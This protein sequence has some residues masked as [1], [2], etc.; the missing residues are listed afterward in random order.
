MYCFILSL[1]LTILCFFVRML[2]NLPLEVH[3]TFA[4]R[5]ILCIVMLCVNELSFK[6]LSYN[7]DLTFLR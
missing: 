2:I 5:P 1:V 4:N 3:N 6:V 7:V